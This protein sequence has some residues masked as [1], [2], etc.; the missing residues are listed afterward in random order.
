MKSHYVPEII[1]R[2]LKYSFIYHVF[3]AVIFQIFSKNC[4][5]ESLSLTVITE[6]QCS[7]NLEMKFL[8]NQAMW[9]IYLNASSHA[10]Q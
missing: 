1:Y 7:S 3:C 4:T 10:S 6:T 2:I 8:I 5:C 9:V